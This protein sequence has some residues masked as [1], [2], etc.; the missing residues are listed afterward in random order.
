MAFNA[1]LHIHSPFSMA[2][3]KEMSPASLIE[4]ARVKGIDILGTGDALH[5]TW[6]SMWADCMDNDSDILIVP[7]M[8]VEGAGKVHHLILTETLDGAA[9]IA[10]AF[11]PFSKNIDTSGRPYVALTGGEILETVHACGGIAGPAHAFTPWTGMYGR[12]DSL[13]ECY[14]TVTPD[15]LELGLSADSSYGAGIS[16][17]DGIP[18]LSNSDAHSPTPLKVG[19]E[20]TRI[21]LNTR[22]PKSVLRQICAGDIALNVGYFPDEGKYNQTACTRCYQKFTVH[23]AEEMSWRCPH[24]GGQIKMGVRDRALLHSDDGFS[25]RPP[26]VHMIPLGEI[27]RQVVGTSSPLTKKCRVLYSALTDTLGTEISI[28]MDMPLSDI[29]EVDERV[30]GAISDFRTG[31]VIFH[32]GGGGKYGTFT[33]PSLGAEP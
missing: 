25:S 13:L 12:Y 5:P 30:A 6:R 32:P 19:R 18:F 4:A 20:F 8:E 22:T 21:R 23:E 9:R 16:E 14:G 27:V 28:Q 15:F 24:D 7:T 10:D 33:L 17:L 2:V 3:S 26:Y 1:D 29:A 11:R 31:N